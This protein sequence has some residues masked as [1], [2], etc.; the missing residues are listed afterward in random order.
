MS[1]TSSPS[2]QLP[3]YRGFTVRVSILSAGSAVLP[4]AMLVQPTIAGRDT[5]DISLYSFLVE[6]EVA[7]KKLLFDLGFMK[8]WE[9][10][11]P[12]LSEFSMNPF[13]QSLVAA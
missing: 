6:N 4:T 1:V 3:A 5:M 7:G 2:V 12:P 13:L 9:E 10:K 11:L 8:A